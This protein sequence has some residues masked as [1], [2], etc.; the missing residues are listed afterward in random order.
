[1]IQGGSFSALPWLAYILA[2]A[3]NAICVYRY[4]AMGINAQG[5]RIIPVRICIDDAFEPFCNADLSRSPEIRDQAI[6]VCRRAGI[7]YDFPA[8]PFLY[9]FCFADFVFQGQP[10]GL[11]GD[12]LRAIQFRGNKAEKTAIRHLAYVYIPLL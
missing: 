10:L 9:R 8:K 2:I 7:L 5:D 3:L 12:P 11:Q 6:L 4:F 1:M